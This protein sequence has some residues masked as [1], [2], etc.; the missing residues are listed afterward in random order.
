MSEEIT[1]TASTEGEVAMTQEGASSQET[2]QPETLYANKYKSVSELEKG[3]EHL[4]SKLGSFQGAPDEYSLNEG[5]ESDI[6][7][8]LFQKIMEVGRDM[9]LNNDGFNALVGAYNEVLQA[10]NAKFEEQRNAE[11]AKLGDNAKER[12]QNI[13]DW[14]NANLTEAERDLMASIS[15]SADAVM[16]LEKF[17]SM[18]KP[19]GV[20]NE[21]QA[22]ARPSY[23]VDKLHAM[24]YAKDEHGNRRM[25]TDPEYRKKVL[26][27][28]AEYA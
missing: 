16:L 27:L 10:E 4:Q 25:S 23:D 22:T 18:S 14:G 12:V 7:S 3:Y 8:P 17:I 2:V 11:F 15:T 6:E 26:A 1:Q 5:V 28:E 20:A 19:Q 13:K 24:R 21:Q 9:N